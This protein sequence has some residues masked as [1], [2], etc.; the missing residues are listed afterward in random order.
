M[1]LGCDAFRRLNDTIRAMV[2]AFARGH[3]GM[4]KQRV[5]RVGNCNG[6][7]IPQVS[8]SEIP[9][10]QNEMRREPGRRPS[11]SSTTEKISR[12]DTVTHGHF[13]KLRTDWHNVAM[14][15]AMET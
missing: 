8:P 12:Y 1:S 11:P 5:T 15:S 14:F 3:E 13:T 4:W 9:F 7:T 2:M 6:T 10:G